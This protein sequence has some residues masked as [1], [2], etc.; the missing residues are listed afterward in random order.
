M[1]DEWKDGEGNG[2]LDVEVRSV[3]VKGWR[4]HPFRTRMTTINKVDV[5]SR[6]EKSLQDCFYIQ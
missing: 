6:L 1:I 4:G 3:L 5:K 2:S